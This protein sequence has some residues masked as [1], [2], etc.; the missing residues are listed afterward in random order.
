MHTLGFSERKSFGYEVMYVVRR[1]I[2]LRLLSL[3]AAAARIFG[4][5][6]WTL[7]CSSSFDGDFVSIL[8]VSSSYVLACCSK[9]TKLGFSCGREIVRMS[10]VKLRS[11][12]RTGIL[13]IKEICG[14]AKDW[15]AVSFELHQHVEESYDLYKDRKLENWRVRIDKSQSTNRARQ[16]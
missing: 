12:M 6:I 1:P 7:V 9:T 16:E 2:L 10:S 3:T 5:H 8:F 13:W 15:D 4:S 11:W 14:E